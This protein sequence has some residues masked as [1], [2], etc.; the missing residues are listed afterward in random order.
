MKK[1]ISFLEKKALEVRKTIIN[2]AF[3]AGTAHLSSS[4]SIVDILTVLYWDT[5]KISPRKPKFPNRDRFILSKGHG[6]SALYSTLF[7]REFFSDKILCTYCQEGSELLGH[8]EYGSASGIEATSGALGHGLSIAAGF[9][10]VAKLDKK[11]YRSFIIISDGECD[12]GSIWEAALFSSHHKLD[13]L[14]A[15]VDYNKFQAFGKTNEVLTLEPFAKKW[16]SFGWGVKEID[17]NNILEIKKTLDLIP[18]NKGKPSIIIAHTIAGK[19]VSFAENKLEWH[20]KN[21]DK[22]LFEQ[23]IKEIEE[24]I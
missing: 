2:M 1:N 14:I 24:K 12:E 13:N 6:V 23:A 15:I 19:G 5:M 4:L 7:H 20:Y 8:P 18:F 11:K 16:E 21:L 17:G 22:S 3:K 9:A 10:L